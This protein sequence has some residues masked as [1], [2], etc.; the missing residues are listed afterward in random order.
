MQ[1]GGSGQADLIA[2]IGKNVQYLIHRMH[3]S[4]SYSYQEQTVDSVKNK[5]KSAALCNIQYIVS[6]RTNTLP[7]KGFTFMD[8]D[9]VYLVTDDGLHE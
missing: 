1:S 9:F 5:V 7:E 3:N 8:T 6:F 4:L 2:I